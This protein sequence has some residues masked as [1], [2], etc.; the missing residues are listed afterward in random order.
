MTSF[1]GIWRRWLRNTAATLL[2]RRG[3]R[4]V[5][6]LYPPVDINIYCY[7]ENFHCKNA[8]DLTIFISITIQRCCR[9][10]VNTKLLW[11]GLSTGTNSYSLVWIR[12]FHTPRYELPSNG[13]TAKIVLHDR[14]LLFFKV[15]NLDLYI[16]ETI[17]VSAK[18]VGDGMNSYIQ[19]QI[20]ILYLPIFK[21]FVL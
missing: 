18:C 5:H 6:L 21:A 7:L 9:F 10:Q 16:F 13:I 4:D 12:T 20:W 3:G 14:D 15:K 11:I 19:K 1:T 8:L 2:D 17:R